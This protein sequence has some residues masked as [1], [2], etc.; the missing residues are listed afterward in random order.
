MKAFSN[1]PFMNDRRP[2]SDVSCFHTCNCS[3][4]VVD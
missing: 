1:I 4:T 3:I 2:E